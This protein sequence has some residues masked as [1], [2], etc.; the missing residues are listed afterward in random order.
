M[1]N[2]SVAA[3]EL[4]IS[5]RTIWNWKAQGMPCKQIGNVWKV[6]SVDQVVKWLESRKG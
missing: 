5:K 1:I 4:G 3:K 2:L 6:D